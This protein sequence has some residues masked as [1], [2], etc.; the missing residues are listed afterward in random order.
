MPP[1]NADH[2]GPVIRRV[3]LNNQ[4]KNETKRDETNDSLN[5]SHDLS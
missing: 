4:I 1:G 3:T 2:V 5:A